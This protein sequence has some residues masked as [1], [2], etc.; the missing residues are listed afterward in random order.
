VLLINVDEKDQV[1]FLISLK[2]FFIID[3][4]YECLADFKM[5]GFFN[6]IIIESIFDLIIEIFL[7]N[8]DIHITLKYYFLN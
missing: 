4:A 3:Y 2:I 8:I 7:N 1:I 6:F 5:E